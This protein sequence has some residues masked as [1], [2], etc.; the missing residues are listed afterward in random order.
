[1]KKDTLFSA[2]L[3]IVGVLLFLLKA[4]GMTA[5]IVLSVVGLALLVVYAVMTKKEWKKPALEILMRVFYAIALITGVVIIN[6]D[7]VA[8]LSVVHKACAALFVV[9]LVVL[10]VLKGRT[11]VK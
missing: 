7:G 4:T 3:F 10:F 1:M 11:K 8:L 2:L 6:V 5:H 9:L